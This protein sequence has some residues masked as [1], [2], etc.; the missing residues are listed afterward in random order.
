MP[1]AIMP[2]SGLP[3]RHITQTIDATAPNAR[4]DGR[5][6]RDHRELH[7]RHCERR[8]G[9]EAEPTEEQDERTEHRHR[10]VVTGQRP[11]LAVLE[12]ADAGTDHDCTGER[13]SSAHCVHDAG[14]GEVDVADAEL[15]AVA[16]L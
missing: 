13:G 16:E 1:L 8:G 15:C 7:V 9:V 11:W 12:L 6:G 2:G 10:D 5:V 3:V 4:S 14:A